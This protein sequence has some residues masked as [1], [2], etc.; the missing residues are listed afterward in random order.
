MT[1]SI[2]GQSI[3]VTGGAGFIGSHL[4]D[5]LARRNSVLVVD[6]LSVG[7]MENLQRHQSGNKVRIVK[8]DVR[9][10]DR[11]YGLTRDIDVVYHLA[12]QCIRLSIGDPELV[13]EVN[14]TGTLNMLLA[15][16]DSGVKRFIYVSSSEAYGS[17]R[18]V[19]MNEE[20]P[21]EPTTPYGASKAAGELYTRSFYL[22]YG[23]PTII[24]RPFNTYGPRAHFAGA[25]GEVI[26]KFV[27]RALNDIPPVIFGD[28]RQT[29]DFT[30]VEDTVHGIILASGC[31][32][33]IGDAI[34]M[35]YGEETSID[36]LARIV[37]REL[38]KDDLQPEYQAPRP[39][40]VR[41][42]YSDITKSVELLGFRPMTS[43]QEGIR[44]YVGWLEEQEVDLEKQLQRE[45]VRNWEA[46]EDG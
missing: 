14:T 38:G 46:V 22:T 30:Y 21:L 40:D 29:R 43:I 35:G 19:P 6:D 18:N 17:A 36:E 37:L 25:Y 10:K 39:G 5:A 24:V 32:R 42:H 33:L 34:N 11:M 9:D 1:D 28:G 31:E 27:I 13:H 12:V 20:H 16:R 23:L 44:K 3:L 4:V 45:T 26:P 8:A 2:V 41:R 15:S 7:T